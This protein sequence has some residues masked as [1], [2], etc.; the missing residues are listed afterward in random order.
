[1]LKLYF[2]L[3]TLIIACLFSS[4]AIADEWLKAE[5]KNFIIMSN[6]SEKETIAYAQNLEKFRFLLVNFYQE[7]EIRELENPKL[8]VYLLKKDSDLDKVWPNHPKNLGGFANSSIDGV[9]AFSLAFGGV[10]QNY[11]DAKHLDENENQVVLF[12]E[13]TH[14]LMQ[15]TSGFAYPRWYIEGFAEYYS[16]TRITNENALVG[17]GSNERIYTLLNFSKIKYEDILRDKNSSKKDDSEYESMF[18]AQSWILTH[19]LMSDPVLRSKMPEYFVKIKEGHDEVEAFEDVF[20]I[21]VKDLDKILS[22]YLYNFKATIYKF[23][24][25]QK[26][27]KVDVFKYPKSLN[28]LILLDAALRVHPSYNESR[29]LITKIENEANNIKDSSFANE[30]LARSEAIAGDAGKAIEF[31]KS[32]LVTSPDN[33]E[34]YSR[35]GEA[36]LKKDY[37]DNN[38]HIENLKEARKNL[39]KAY[40]LDPN[41]ARTL[42]YLSQTAPTGISN[43]EEAY[44]NAAVEAY[45]ISPS[46]TDYAFNA[47]FMLISTKKFD[48]AKDL[49]KAFSNDPHDKLRGKVST[50][51]IKFIDEGGKPSSIIS[52]I[53]KYKREAELEEL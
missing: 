44:V 27:I 8:N 16:T 20:S 30:Y 31:Y 18:Y 4:N 3:I 40:Q 9:F 12:H 49:L 32:V 14:L 19:Y 28:N 53:L 46:V 29:E 36:Y 41:N 17:Y 43:P 5:T 21:K 7:K 2:R 42:Y 37:D 47:V 23:R 6:W 24:E 15:I 25:V 10:L 22:K 33:P 50:A 35:I 38:E 34:Y 51:A 52:K 39:Y 48:D 26:D 11:K 45:L 1:M 13:Y